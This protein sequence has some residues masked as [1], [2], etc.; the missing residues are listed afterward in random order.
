MI[1]HSSSSYHVTAVLQRHDISQQQFIS[2]Y[3]SVTAAWYLAAAVHITLQQHDIS[4][5][6]FISRYSSVTAA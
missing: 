3:S 5:Q 6:Q 4:Q 2:R 1:S